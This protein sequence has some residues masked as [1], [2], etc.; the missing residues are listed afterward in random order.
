M[1]GALRRGDLQLAFVYI[2]DNAPWHAVEF[3][4]NDGLL[5]DS[6]SERIALVRWLEHQKHKFG[7]RA[8]NIHQRGDPVNWFRIGF[9]SIEEAYAFLRDLRIR[10]RD[11]DM[12]IRW[13]IPTEAI[14]SAD[15]SGKEGLVST[16]LGTDMLDVATTSSDESLFGHKYH[17]QEDVLG[18]E[19][20]SVNQ[21]N[22]V[23]A[24]NCV[25]VLIDHVL[26][27]TDSV[28]EKMTYQELARR[29]N[30]VDKHGEPAAL[31]LGRI[32]GLAMEHVDGAARQLG[33]VVPFLTSIVVSKT[34]KG[35]GLPSDGVRE[36][37]AGY[38]RLT[39]AEKADKAA[40]E[41]MRILLFGSR[42]NDV[43]SVLGLPPCQVAALPP[44]SAGRGGGESVAHKAFKAYIRMRPDL[45]GAD[46]T[47]DSEEEFALRSQDEIDVLFKSK[48][49][50]AWI[51]VEVK[52]AVS[53]RNVLDYR[54]GLYQI[55]KYQ[56]VLAAQA[57]V[58]NPLTPPSVKVV[59]ALESILPEALRAEARFLGV[60]VLENLGPV[61]DSNAAD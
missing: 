48:S 47:W 28:M 20:Q 9:T 59:L 12:R 26:R 61:K 2:S 35:K 7:G 52:S 36:R 39:R 56:A 40:A 15:L 19:E 41:Y 11:P 60:A 29:L 46:A 51:G 5:T 6:P 32:L 25:Q 57:L 14:V 53:D 23:Y 13:T 44:G 21:S 55:V 18:R 8:S 1:L 45:V 17:R 38:D 34:G 24:L 22:D 31:G 10:F 54:R 37:W 50:D 27:Q 58:D 4:L 16:V 49:G 30:R 43:L 3:A 42:W 33:W